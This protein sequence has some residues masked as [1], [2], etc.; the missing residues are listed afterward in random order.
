MHVATGECSSSVGMEAASTTQGEPTMTLN[1][2]SEDNPKL[3][4]IKMFGLALGLE[5][6]EQTD[7][8]Q[9]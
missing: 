1:L 7:G 6:E 8:D 4:V 3:K 9:W 2:S 5:G